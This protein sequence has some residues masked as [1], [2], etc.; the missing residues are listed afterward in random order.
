MASR[1]AKTSHTS[2]DLVVGRERLAHMMTHSEAER[3]FSLLLLHFLLQLEATSGVKAVR[4]GKGERSLTEETLETLAPTLQ[5]GV[6]GIGWDVWRSPED[7]WC[8]DLEA[9]VVENAILQ[10]DKSQS[11]TGRESSKSPYRRPV[12]G[13]SNGRWSRHTCILYL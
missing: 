11:R 10:G 1:G 4:G 5:H 12:T 2:F 8:Q 13:F 9:T 6:A 3:S 7:L